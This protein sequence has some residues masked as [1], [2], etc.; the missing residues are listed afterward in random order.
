MLRAPTSNNSSFLSSLLLEGWRAAG[1]VPFALGLGG[2]VQTP[3]VEPL[4]GTVVVVAPD[5]LAV[6]HLVAEAVGRLVGVHGHVQHLLG[7]PG[8]VGVRVTLARR[9]GRGLVLLLLPLLPLRLL[10]AP[11]LLVFG[12]LLDRNLFLFFLL[13]F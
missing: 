4:D 2:D 9:G 12:F 13:C 1:T 6:G 8:Q 3:E 7:H 11:L 5:H 10:H